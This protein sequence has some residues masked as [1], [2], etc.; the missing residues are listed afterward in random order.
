MRDDRPDWDDVLRD[1]ARREGWREAA[2]S[3]AEGSDDS[4]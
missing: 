4:E 3:N 1:E 2:R